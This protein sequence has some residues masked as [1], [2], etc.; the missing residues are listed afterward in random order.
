LENNRRSV[1]RHFH[2]ESVR[3]GFEKLAPA[4]LDFVFVKLAGLQPGN[5]EFPNARITQ[6][7][8][9]VVRAIPAVEVAD[10]ADLIGTWRPNSKRDPAPAFVSHHMRA[11]LFIDA[12]VLALAE[13]MKIEFA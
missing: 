1:G 6:T 3:I 8:H 9:P 5:E 11:Q 10:D 2:H 7:P 4:V 12:I 13:E